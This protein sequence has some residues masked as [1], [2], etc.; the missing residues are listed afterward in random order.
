LPVDNLLHGD[1]PTDVKLE[2]AIKEI[3]NGMGSPKFRAAHGQWVPYAW[4][5]RGL[6]ENGHG[7]LDSVRA[8]VDRAK[9]HPE[10]VATRSVRAAYYK[11]RKSPWPVSSRKKKPQ[12]ISD[13]NDTCDTTDD[14]EV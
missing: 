2:E 7:V 14:F 13:A 10:D 6:V 4:V 1:N 11:I 9:L 8:V 5:V 3:R 12:D